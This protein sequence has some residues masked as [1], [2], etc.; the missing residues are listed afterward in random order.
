MFVGQLLQFLIIDPLVIAADAVGN[1]RVE[2]SEKSGMAWVRW[3][4]WARFIPSTVSPGFEQREVDRHVRLRARVRLDVH[5]VR[6]KELLRA[7]IATTRDIDELA[8]AVIPLPGSP[9]VLVVMTE[10]AA[11]STAVLTKFSEA[12]NSNPLPDGAFVFDRVRDLSVVSASER[13]ID[14]SEEQR[15]A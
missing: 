2:L 13:C 5:V 12:I 9:R 1:D 11:S 3:P 6:A 14:E 15:R 4:P 8:P 10:P 7:E